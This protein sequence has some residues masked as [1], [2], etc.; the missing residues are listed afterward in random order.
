MDVVRR[1]DIDGVHFDDY[2]YPYPQ[3]AGNR[4]LD[5]PD[6]T[7]WRRYQESGGK[8]ARNDWRRENV[9]GL[10]QS[11]YDQ[12][13]KEKPWVKFGVSPFGIWQPNHPPGIVGLNADDKLYGDARKWLALGWVDYLAPQLYWAIGDKP[14]SF[15][16][17]LKWWESQNTQHRLL[18]AGMQVRSWKNIANESEE[19]CD[20]ISLVRGQPGASGEI[21][22]HAG[23]IM[24]NHAG[25]DEAL[26][27]I[28]ADAA[29]VPACRWLQG[30]TPAHPVLSCKRTRW[31]FR[32]T[33]T[34]ESGPVWKW[35]VRT[36]SGNAWKTEVLP[37]RET[38]EI[39]SYTPA[40]ITVAAVNRFGNLSPP[41][42]EMP[43]SR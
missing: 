39:L 21:L 14:H 35:V 11:V 25:I 8:L 1:Y 30:P 26:R 17:L 3:K 42:T 29:L 4:E 37:G 19:A 40:L 28:Y 38:D 34:E 7:T 16:V 15:P 20:E 33:W 23:P 22:W 18:L 41:A 10:I 32:A 13:K 36:K 43:V 2:F 24:T 27:K 9:N 12:I 5:F 31:Q 6:D